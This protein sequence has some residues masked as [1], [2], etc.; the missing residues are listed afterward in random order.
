MILRDGD[1]EIVAVSVWG[2]E[3]RLRLSALVESAKGP[4]PCCCLLVVLESASILLKLTALAGRL[5][6]ITL[7]RNAANVIAELLKV[8]IEE[9]C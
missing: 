1:L 3:L 4:L 5:K 2:L 7:L 6:E 8:R 9:P